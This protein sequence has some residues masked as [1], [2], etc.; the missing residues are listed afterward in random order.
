MKRRGGACYCR[1][2][3][4]QGIDKIPGLYM[5]AAIMRMG[6]GGICII[7]GDFNR[8][9]AADNKLLKELK[10]RITRLEKKKRT[11][12]E[13]QRQMELATFVSIKQYLTV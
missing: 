2:Y 7:K 12:Y 4:R 6:K 10:A 11:L 13:E 9:I 1:S 3:K 8:V 5:D